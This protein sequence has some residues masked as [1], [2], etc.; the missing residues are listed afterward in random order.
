MTK[1]KDAGAPP[2]QYDVPF[3]DE[4]V[5]IWLANGKRPM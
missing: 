3:K 5:R 1:K 2:R 4:A